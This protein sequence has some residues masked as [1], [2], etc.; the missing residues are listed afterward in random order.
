[1]IFA[2]LPAGGHSTRMGR[3][4]LALPLG[5]RTLLEHVIAA[6]RAAEIEH[7]LVVLGPHVAELAQAAGAHVHILPEATPDMR[8][9]V[10]DGLRWLEER[11]QPK[12]DDCWLLVPADHPT[13]QVEVVR[14]LIS[15][16]DTHPQRSIFVPTYQAKRGHPTLLAWSHVPGIRS[17]PAGQGI[18]TYLRQQI[19][20]TLEVAVDSAEILLDLDTPEDYERL[21]RE[22]PLTQAAPVKRVT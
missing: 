4:K 18:N 15:A 11:F 9:T 20:Q 21:L 7:V 5:G 13:L 8:A 2:V 22:W 14:S 10:E 16:R 19:D 1:M 6:L 17:L 12:R 3:P